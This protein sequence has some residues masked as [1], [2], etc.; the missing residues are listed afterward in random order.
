MRLLGR[1]SARRGE[2]TIE[3]FRSQ[4]T[5][6]LFAY[7]C[8]HA[9]SGRDH[10]REELADLLWPDDDPARARASL[11]VALAFIRRVL[12]PPPAPS[13][14]VLVAS[15]F[16]VRLR[17]EAVRADVHDFEAAL[18]G[19]DPA[20][21]AEA[22]TRYRESGPFLPGVYEEWALQ[23]RERLEALADE[24]FRT[25]PPAAA[26]ASPAVRSSG[27]TRPAPPTEP[28]ATLA[29]A[30]PVYADRFFGRD[31]ELERLETLL[32]GGARVVALTGA[33][34][35]GKTRLAVEAARRLLRADGVGQEK[36]APAGAFPGGAWF[37]PL[38]EAADADS[39]PTDLAFRL[40]ASMGL[41][42]SD[43]RRDP[44]AQAAEHLAGRPALLVLDNLEQVA[45]GA[46][47]ALPTLLAA[48]PEGTAL[49]LTSRIRTGA[50]GERPVAVRPLPVPPEGG[51]DAPGMLSRNPAAALFADRARAV[52]AD[53]AVTAANAAAVADLSRLLDGVPLALELA[54]SWAS[55]LSPARMCAQLREHLDALPAR[56][57]A[58]REPR[59]RSLGAA[60]A[61]SLGL[62]EPEAADLLGRL[63][64]FHGGF[65]AGSVAAVAGGADADARGVLSRLARLHQHS[66]LATRPAGAAGDVRFAVPP[67]LRPFADA[68]LGEG[69]RS[70][71]RARHA[72]HFLGAAEAAKAKIGT[73]DA[74]AALEQLALEREDLLGALRW[75]AAE[76]G[77][78]ETALRL[79]ASLQWLWTTRGPVGEGRRL[80]AAVVTLPAA[81]RTAVRADALNALGGM[82]YFEGDTGAAAEYFAESLGLCRELS[83]AR[84]TLV[85]LG[86]L[87]TAHMERGEYDAARPLL[88]EAREIARAAGD[89]VR[90]ASVAYN[91]GNLA[92]WRGDLHDARCLHDEA[93][94]MR[95]SAGDGRGLALSLT[96]LGI[97]DMEA[98]GYSAAEGRFRE[99]LALQGDLGDRFR[100]SVTLDYLARARQG[101]GDG[102]PEALAAAVRLRAA[103]ETL[104][105][106]LGTPL[107]PHRRAVWEEEEVELRARLGDEA[108][109]AARAE[110]SSL[111]WA[112]ACRLLQLPR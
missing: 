108:F 110:G 90:G 70:G 47:A 75:A 32:R 8:L 11:R 79:G 92:H 2:E 21:V 12:E 51:P 65:T 50:R 7:L 19:R 88:A 35:T 105:A 16:H 34:G 6:A 49:L 29:G 68:L 1:V 13:G 82:A 80:L 46:P 106:E 74:P 18:R 78:A 62:L 102:G 67:A 15:R 71:L 85:A 81:A 36:G 30:L 86:N 112:A 101:G 107:P 66:L 95:R 69:E 25:V 41:R 37:V 100:A 17:S 31:E 20:A 94:S 27:A 109:A 99:A 73:P 87:G 98:G 111:D 23:E 89:G 43:A 104:R 56:Q 53:F 14:S 44:L 91:L 54:A 77:Q 61:W 26:V 39:L 10:A 4:K 40:R 103:A 52:D 58:A 83:Y 57:P 38:A 60:F 24:A 3:R 48:L 9:P 96:A 64:V 33:G 72:A 55:V 63:S 5:A 59:H 42:E 45:D 22:L 93:L 84:G 28:R 76:P 97:L